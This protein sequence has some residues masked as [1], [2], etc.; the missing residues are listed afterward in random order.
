LH[1]V[2]SRRHRQGV[3]PTQQLGG[4]GAHVAHRGDTLGQ[5]IPQIHR[6]ILTGASAGQEEQVDMAVY[7]SWDEP[8]TMCVYDPGSRRNG[9]LACRS[10]ADDSAVPD[11]GYGVRH[12]WAA[13]TVPQIGSYYGKRGIGSWGYFGLGR[14]SAAGVQS[15]RPK[16]KSEWEKP[17]EPFHL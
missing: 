9:T 2:H 8:L 12:D 10:G 6:Q 1:R 4:I 17:E 5:Q 15:Q 13:G 11:E 3:D 16:K 7:Q 14:A